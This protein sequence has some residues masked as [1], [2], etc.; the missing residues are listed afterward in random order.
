MPNSAT[1]YSIREA[2]L[3]DADAMSHVIVD[4]F[5]AAHRG[6]IPDEVWE[7]RQK[8]WTYEVSALGW[9]RTLRSIEDLTSPQACVFVAEN[10]AG[11]VV[12]V[13][14][15]DKSSVADSC[16]A[17]EIYVLYVHP[18]HQGHGNGRQL[19]GAI[20]GW[21]AQHG[22]TTLH[23][24]VL[25]SNGAA[26]AFYEA[27]GGQVV[28]EREIEDAGHLLPEVVYGWL[29]LTQLTGAKHIDPIE[30]SQVAPGSP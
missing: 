27:L 12:A 9:E 25:K 23:I 17:G 26:R 15:G 19:V 2:N 6:M 18:D 5:L 11:G 30:N 1:Y 7:W 22:M 21:M 8:N 10:G 13:A 29:D 14:M 16:S 24:G 28:I 20:A 3:S 4:T